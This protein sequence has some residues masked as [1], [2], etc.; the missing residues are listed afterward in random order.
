MDSPPLEVWERDIA[1]STYERLR[2]DLSHTNSTELWMRLAS[3]TVRQRAIVYRC[4]AR[5]AADPLGG[6]TPVS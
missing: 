1:R 5:A 6:D 2:R 4:I 3:L